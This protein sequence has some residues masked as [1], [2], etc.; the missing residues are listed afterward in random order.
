[1]LEK[2]A[3][4]VMATL[5]IIKVECAGVIGLCGNICVFKP[6]LGNAI[7]WN[8]SSFVIRVNYPQRRH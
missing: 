2:M 8:R 5:D 7:G 4:G 3:A 6:M 1:M